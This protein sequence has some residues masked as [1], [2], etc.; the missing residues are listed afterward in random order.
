MIETL[1][2][3]A[4]V[5]FIYFNALYIFAQIKKDNSIV[6]IGWGFGF[7]LI[8]WSMLLL[9]NNWQT[10]SLL[11]VGLVSAWG[12]RLLAH[13]YS[14]NSKSGEDWRYAQWRKDWGR[15]VYIRAYFQIFMLQAVMMFIISLPVI[16][17]VTTMQSNDSAWSWL[18]LP[19]VLIWI[20]GFFMEAIADYHLKMHL[21]YG[22]K[23]LL[24]QGVWAFSR[25]PNYFGEA[26]QWWGI[27]LISLASMETL[28]W[29]FPGCGLW[30]LLG[31]ITITLLL[32]YVSGVPILEKKY[33]NRKEFKEYAKKT[34]I[35]FPWF[36]KK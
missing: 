36:P 11:V 29:N 4:L 27:G 34:P 25:H 3:A 30:V 35:F 6:D 21:R 23:G 24:T 5:I 13:I 32:R 20:F 7:V 10:R 12:V 1:L 14:R 26:M 28:G 2:A 17:A 22:K 19:G 18:I 8:A 33:E 16:H 9:S 15:W 31:P